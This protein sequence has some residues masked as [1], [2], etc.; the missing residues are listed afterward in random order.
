MSIDKFKGINE[1]NFNA[2]S[3][4]K[5]LEVIRDN[6]LSTNDK[7]EYENKMKLLEDRIKELE[8][9]KITMMATN[10]KYT[11]TNSSGSVNITEYTLYIPKQS[12]TIL[13]KE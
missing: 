9:Q 4:E 13:V 7:K 8:N 5:E 11:I 1:K 10:V 6:A 2:L 12:F 3:I